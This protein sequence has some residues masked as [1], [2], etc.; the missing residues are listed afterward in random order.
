MKFTPAT[1]ELSYLVRV[2]VG[3]AVASAAVVTAEVTQE[4]PGQAR[5]IPLVKGN[6]Q[7]GSFAG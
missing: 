6:V 3:G 1:L 2:D 7:F 5:Q 4:P